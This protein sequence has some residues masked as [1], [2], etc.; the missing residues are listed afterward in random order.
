MEET[1]IYSFNPEE[2][3]APEAE[4]N[5]TSVHHVDCRFTYSFFLGK[6]KG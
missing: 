4:G 5:L 3:M 2:G 1:L 6:R